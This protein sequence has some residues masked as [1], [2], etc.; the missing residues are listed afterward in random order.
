MTGAV[1]G[2]MILRL[3]GVENA[4]VLLVLTVIFA[5]AIHPNALPVWTG[6]V[7]IVDQK[8]APYVSL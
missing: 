5:I 4:I 8:F 7:G 3:S 2:A 6:C 1:T